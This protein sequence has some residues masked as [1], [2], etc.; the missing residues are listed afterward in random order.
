MIKNKYLVIPTALLVL[1]SL[2]CSFLQLFQ[3]SPGGKII[4]Q[5]D[6]YGN[7]EI[8]AVD[9]ASGDIQRLTNNTANDVSPA[10]NPA[11]G[12]IGFVSDRTDAWYLYAMDPSGSNVIMIAGDDSI[13]IEYPYWSNDGLFITASVV[14]NCREDNCT[15]DIHIMNADGTNR[16]NLTE[17]P[18]S[19]WVPAWSL[20]GQRIAFASDRDGDS[21]IYIMDR[22]GSNVVQLTMNTGHDGRPRWSPDGTTL[23]F[24][25]D[26][27]GG[28]WDVFLMDIDG[29]NVRAVTSNTTQ[30]YGVSWSPDGKWLVFISNI[31][32][33]SEVFIVDLQ[34][35]NME[36][37]THTTGNETAPIWIR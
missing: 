22:D 34:G 12:Q 4:C 32:G 21:E 35:E 16:R 3:S 24:E 36:R 9:I 5:T 15:Y 20:D 27:D 2:A 31:D 26:R 10:Y 7:F 14:E 29:S 8:I 30:E 17:T 1:S 33:N 25:S 28:D 23:A 6:Q 37:L 18:A 11:N 19:E 13:Y